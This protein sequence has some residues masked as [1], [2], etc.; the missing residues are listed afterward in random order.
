MLMHHKLIALLVIIG[1]LIF[2]VAK[3]SIWFMIL[4]V[5]ACIAIPI[6]TRSENLLKIFVPFSV[7]LCIIVFVM[8]VPESQSKEEIQQEFARVTEE[9][10]HYEQRVIAKENELAQARK[11]QGWFRNTFKNS[12]KVKRLEVEVKLLHKEKAHLDE[13]AAKLRRKITMKDLQPIHPFAQ[14]CLYCF[15]LRHCTVDTYYA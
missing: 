2:V 13:Q 11:E 12:E 14:T 10:R 6:I 4:L 8:K 9:L 5:L 15:P 1:I 3:T 7:I